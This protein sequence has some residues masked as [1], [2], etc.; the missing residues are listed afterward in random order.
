MYLSDTLLNKHRTPFLG[1]N[2]VTYKG[3]KEHD[4]LNYEFKEDAVAYELGRTLYL[5]ILMLRFMMLYINKIGQD[6]IT[7]RVRKLV[8]YCINECNKNGI[9]ILSDFPQKNLSG[10]LNI[11]AQDITKAMLRKRAS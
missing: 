4:T 8:T 5:N 7:N 1:Y 3:Q 2:S 9:S 11:K 10:I 6:E